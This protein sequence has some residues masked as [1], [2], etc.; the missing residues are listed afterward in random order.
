MGVRERKGE[1]EAMGADKLFQVINYSKKFGFYVWACRKALK[2][3]MMQ[4]INIVL[5][6]LFMICDQKYVRN[7]PTHTKKEQPQNRGDD[8]GHKMCLHP[9][10]QCKTI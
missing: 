6:M 5:F 10:S 2:F 4:I 7:T 3:Y 1:A 8:F 9:F